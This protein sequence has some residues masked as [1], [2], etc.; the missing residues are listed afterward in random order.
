[1][2]N[3]TKNIQFLYSGMYSGIAQDAIS[4]LMNVHWLTP[5]L[6]TTPLIHTAVSFLTILND[7]FP[8]KGSTNPYHPDPPPLPHT[9]CEISRIYL[10]CVVRTSDDE[11]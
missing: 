1:M 4:A 3:K 9:K 10:P 2:I 6:L 8:Y 7:T 5:V 11:Y